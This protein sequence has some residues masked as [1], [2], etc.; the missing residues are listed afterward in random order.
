MK[1]ILTKLNPVFDHRNRLG[2][3]SIL[4]VNDWVGYNTLKELLSLTDGNLASHIKPLESAGYLEYRKEFVGRRPQTTYA[5]TTAGRT[6]FKEHLDGLE[7]MLNI[8]KEPKDG[9]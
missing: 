1:E 3:M 6:A 8:G 9:G 7:A 5:I 2:I 4:V